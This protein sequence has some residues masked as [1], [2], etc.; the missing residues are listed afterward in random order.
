VFFK[1]SPKSKKSKK[2]EGGRI[3]GKK[4]EINIKLIKKNKKTTE[5]SGN[6]RRDFCGFMFFTP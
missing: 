6:T 2:H 3:R 1:K 5:P 4:I